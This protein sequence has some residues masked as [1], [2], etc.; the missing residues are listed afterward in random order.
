MS[1]AEEGR[2]AM[3]RRLSLLLPLKQYLTTLT[4]MGNNQSYCSQKEGLQVKYPH[5]VYPYK[6]G[7]IYAVIADTNKL[8]AMLND[9]RTRP[10]VKS[11]G[12]CP[13]G[14]FRTNFATG[15]FIALTIFSWDSPALTFRKNIGQTIVQQ[16]RQRSTNI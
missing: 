9:R 6:L 3:A 13:F 7:G 8:P 16:C 2:V 4:C 11:S 15:Q 14:L 12:D 5:C 10:F 1:R